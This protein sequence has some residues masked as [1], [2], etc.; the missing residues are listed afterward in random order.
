[1]TKAAPS[2]VAHAGQAR[3][4]GGLLEEPPHGR[5]GEDGARNMLLQGMSG[6]KISLAVRDVMLPDILV[7]KLMP[8]STDGYVAYW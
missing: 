7:I 2:S 8:Q 6:P 1:M 4:G 5:A 3:N